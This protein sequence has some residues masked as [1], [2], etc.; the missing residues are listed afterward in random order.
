[1]VIIIIIIITTTT[2]TTTTIKDD[3]TINAFMHLKPNPTTATHHS[4]KTKPEAGPSPC[5][6]LSQPPP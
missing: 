6:R 5:N 2:T 3:C 4:T 1:V